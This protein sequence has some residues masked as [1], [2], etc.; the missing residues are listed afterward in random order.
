MIYHDFEELTKE[1]LRKRE[2]SRCGVVMPRDEHTIEAV[3]KAEEEGFITPV[4]IE[5]ESSE[6]AMMKAVESVHEGK[7]DM[8][9]KGLIP[10]SDFMRAILS[11]DSGLKSGKLVSMLT[12][13][14]IPNYHKL[15]AMTDTGICE[16]PNLMQKKEIIDNAVSALLKIGFDEP[17]VAVLSAAE[18]V[19]SRMQSSTDAEVLKH[20]WEN[21]EIKNC[22]LDGP[23][24]IDLALSHEAAEIK[25]YL[26]PVAGEADLLLFPDLVSA[27]VSGKL[28][29][30]VT[31]T[32][33]GIMILGTK[34]PV[35]VCSRAATVET[36]RL[37]I[38]MAAAC[39]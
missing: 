25:G 5:A 30:H 18:I 6:K 11:H 28:L 37:C 23:V 9:M 7:V 15:L 26:S 22:I 21:G 39:R 32:P 16:Q 31:G 36:K 12:V 17:K 14:K 34:V 35:V 27:N 20:M 8:L 1:I 38:A 3:K 2:P 19:N 29:A 10:T 33:A 4:L 24:S 13:R